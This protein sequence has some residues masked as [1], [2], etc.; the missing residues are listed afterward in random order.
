MGD[1]QVRAW[2]VPGVLKLPGHGNYWPG[3]VHAVRGGERDEVVGGADDADE[4][5]YSKRRRPGRCLQQLRSQFRLYL[6]AGSVVFPVEG[7]LRLFMEERREMILVLGWSAA[8]GILRVPRRRRSASLAVEQFPRTAASRRT[9]RRRSIRLIR[10][11]QR[12]RDNALGRRRTHAH[13]PCRS[14]PPPPPPR[15]SFLG[16]WFRTGQLSYRTRNPA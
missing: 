7:R 11:R 9:P 8:P 3:E 12:R 6:A 16:T 1:T 4:A 2:R 5:I 14:N 13:H 15:C 10:C